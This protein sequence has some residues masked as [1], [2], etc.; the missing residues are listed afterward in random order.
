MHWKLTFYFLIGAALANEGFLE[1]PL[2]AHTVGN[3]ITRRNVAGGTVENLGNFYYG[4]KVGVGSPQQKMEI[5]LDTC[6]SDTLFFTPQSGHP[7]FFDK[8]KST[9]CQLVPNQPVFS[10]SFQPENIAATG[11]FYRDTAY[12]YNAR[13]NLQF[14]LLDKDIP[15]VFD[16]V[17]GLFGIGGTGLEGTSKKYTNFPA[18]LV[19]D[20]VIDHLGYSIYLNARNESTGTIVFGGV[21]TAKYQGDI[22]WLRNK[23]PRNTYFGVDVTVNGITQVAM[24]DTG[25]QF[26]YL[27]SKIVDSIAESFSGSYD[28]SKGIVVPNPPKN[29][30]PFLFEFGKAKIYVPYEDLLADPENHH[31]LAIFKTSESGGIPLLGSAFLRS[32][33][34]VYDFDRN[35]A[36]IAQVK[37]T[38]ESAIVPLSQGIPHA[39]QPSWGRL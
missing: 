20:G 39:I 32:A 8:K 12:F 4:A 36:A 9:S 7:Q 37:H 28:P 24:L 10:G 14:A 33:Y 29:P 18:Q 19:L 26:L 6:S 3:Q 13:M 25:T 34:V 5:I 15:H 30:E 1:V 16:H 35:M 27:S 38:T 22:Y 11:N 2:V 31:Q 23:K 17:G 21:D